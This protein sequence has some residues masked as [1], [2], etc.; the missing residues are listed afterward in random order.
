LNSPALLA[1]YFGL[2]LPLRHRNPA[3]DVDS[4]SLASSTG[5]SVWFGTAAMIAE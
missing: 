2:R 3:V 1:W 4:G 5:L